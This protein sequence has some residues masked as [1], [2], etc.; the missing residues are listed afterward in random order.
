M[1]N[2]S[3][4]FVF[5]VLVCFLSAATFDV[6]Y[7][8]FN[9][10][11]ETAFQQAIS[12]WEPLINS[13]IPI[14]I[15]ARF[16][17]VPG[18]V[19][20]SIPN[21]IRNFP[22][23]PHPTIWYPNAL[24]NALTS[25][26]LNPAEADMDFIINPNTPWYYGIDGNCPSNQFNF[27]LEMMKGIAY[28]LGYQTS[29]YISQG[30]G[31]YGMLDPS[32]LGLQTSF[33]WEQMQGYP[34]LYDTFVSNAQGQSLTDPSQFTNPSPALA[35]QLTGGAL[36]F[37]APNAIQ[38][39][40][41][42]LPI[43]FAGAFNLAQT[44]R[45]SNAQ[46]AS[47]ENAT[48]CPTA[49]YGFSFLKP[50]PIVL[51]MLLD[52]GWSI[53]LN[54]LMT[55]PQN[56]E[57]TMEINAIALSWQLP[58]DF[59]HIHNYIIYRNNIIIGETANLYFLDTNVFEN[60]YSYQ[61]KAIYSIGESDFSNQVTISYTHIENDIIMPNITNL[62]NAYPNPFNPKTSISFI[63]KNNETA[64]FEIYNLKGQIVKKYPKFHSGNH[65][66]E[67]LGDDN[68]GTPVG[69]GVYLY[70]L[71]SESVVQI[72]KMLLLK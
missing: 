49:A 31:S 62:G 53:N 60:T 18:F 54:F 34:C 35:A 51:G 6:T 37:V 2:V 50:S 24:A 11:Q 40:S 9:T 66:V 48:G 46:Y 36:R 45:L 63:V 17:N 29:F 32:V 4:M 7:L 21:F 26:E 8:G 10:Q 20:I 14:K 57:A 58:D 16:Q 13:D 27:S 42:Q 3:L 41:N 22:G 23:S 68:S 67:W 38:F 5:A 55:P 39:N 72:R 70:K 28:G 64:M 59:Y 30:Y 43:L 61:I 19:F 33:T 47:S 69:S 15:N 25:T 52:M 1:K 71:T 44:A 65:T 12:I 56:L